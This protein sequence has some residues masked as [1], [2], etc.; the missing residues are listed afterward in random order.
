MFGLSDSAIW[1]AYLLNILSVILTIVYG[2]V[3]WN[4]G[5]DL[6]PEEVAE[7]TAWAQEETEIEKDFE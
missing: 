7:E 2:I 5:G 1:L 6:P 4:K 3:N